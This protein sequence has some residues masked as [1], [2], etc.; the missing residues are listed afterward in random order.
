MIGL[1]TRLHRLGPNK[2]PLYYQGGERIDR[3]RGMPSSPGPEDWVGSVTPL[4]PAVIPGATADLGVSR[5][6][7]G[8]S[9]AHAVAADPGGWLGPD[10]ATAFGGEP[11]LLVKLL[12]AGERLPV[13]WHPD[14]EFARRRLGMTF[15]KTEAWVVLSADPG[16]GVWLGCRRDVSPV[17]LRE[18]IAAGDDAAMLE[19]LNRLDA[20][21]GD[22][23]Y[24]PGGLPHSIGAGILIAEVQE[25]TSLAVV[26]EAV[27]FGMDEEKAT[28]GLGWTDGIASARL[29]AVTGD[30]LR[31]LSPPR[32]TI[33]SGA[34]GTIT[35][36]FGSEAEPFFQVHHVRARGSLDLGDPSFAVLIV[37]EGAGTVRWSSDATD[38][39]QGETLVVPF[40]AGSLTVDGTVEILVCLP[41]RVP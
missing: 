15:G 4:P 35:R 8:T 20:H 37:I 31:D 40:R 38:V 5:L 36:V 12:D 13:H 21:K 17:E 14:R 33:T 41:P 24:V 34:G 29:D 28:L 25:P 10:L 39:H 26:A 32:P 23:F 2:L 22:A 30:A 1:S 9:L 18:W 16:A 27:R 3:F 19:A 7:D 6:P 11:G